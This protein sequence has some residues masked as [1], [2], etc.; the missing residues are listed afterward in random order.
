MEILLLFFLPLS[1]SQML[2]ITSPQ[3]T[4]FS[5]ESLLISYPILSIFF[6]I[7]LACI[8]ITLSVRFKI[9][10]DKQ[11]QIHWVLKSRTLSLKETKPLLITY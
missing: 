11:K 3:E 2:P 1:S 4:D 10:Y 6:S 8:M 7:L 9:A 5:F